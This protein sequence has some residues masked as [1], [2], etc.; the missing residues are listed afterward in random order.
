M[1]K[2]CRRHE[3]LK[4]THAADKETQKAGSLRSSSNQDEHLASQPIV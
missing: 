4:I 1:C 3:L 2:T